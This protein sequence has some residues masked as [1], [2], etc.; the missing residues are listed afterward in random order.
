MTKRTKA[1]NNGGGKTAQKSPNPQEKKK[2]RSSL[3]ETKQE[4]N[5]DKTTEKDGSA[6][7]EASLNLVD[8]F[9]AAAEVKLAGRQHIWKNVISGPKSTWDTISVEIKS[10][11]APKNYLENQE[12]R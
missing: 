10:Q 6:S 4:K 7:T 9:N 3:E 8:K 5:P 11:H 1:L 12:Y 2:C